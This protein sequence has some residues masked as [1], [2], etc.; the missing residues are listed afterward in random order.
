MDKISSTIGA[1][2]WVLIVLLSSA[3][4]TLVAGMYM[5]PDLG[6]GVGRALLYF[7]VILGS[8]LALAILVVS[9]ALVLR[10]NRGSNRNQ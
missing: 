2:P 3:V 9:I 7:S 6:E 8:G 1:I 10:I 5:I 4:V